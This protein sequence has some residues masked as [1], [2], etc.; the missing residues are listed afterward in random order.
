M[1]SNV[2]GHADYLIKFRLIWLL[3]SLNIANIKNKQNVHKKHLHQYRPVG[4]NSRTNSKTG[5]FGGGNTMMTSSSTHN[6]TGTRVS[7]IPLTGSVKSSDSAGSENNIVG[8]G[9]SHAAVMGASGH[10]VGLEEDT[11]ESVDEHDDHHTRHHRISTAKV[12]PEDREVGHEVDENDDM[13]FQ[14]NHVDKYAIHDDQ[15]HPHSKHHHH[16]LFHNH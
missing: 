5:M 6:T 4:K 12:I 2:S 8:I 3:F 14:R 9:I 16:S 13:R 11:N 15:H 7:G 1:L 10:L